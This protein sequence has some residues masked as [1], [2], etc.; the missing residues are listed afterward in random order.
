MICIDVK[1]IASIIAAVIGLGSLVYNVIQ[2]IVA[3]KERAALRGLV[4]GD[5]NIYFN[6]AR[7]CGRARKD[8]LD[9]KARLEEACRALEVIRGCADA[10]RT[11][12]LSFSREHLSFLPYYEHPAEPGKPQPPEVV[13]GMTPERYRFL[14]ESK[15]QKAGD[16]AAQPAAQ[17]EPLKRPA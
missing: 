12:L 7:Q 6:I 4:Q 17:A 2:F 10:G 15:T 9:D 16:S 8:E 5:Y 3:R 14:Q 11:S 1:T 13:F